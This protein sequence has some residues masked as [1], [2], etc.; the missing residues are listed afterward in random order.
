MPLALLQDLLMQKWDERID[1]ILC[2]HSLGAAIAQY[3]VL[4]LTRC[5]VG[6]RGGVLLEDRTI[7][8]FTLNV[9]QVPACLRQSHSGLHFR[10]EASSL[11]FC[12]PLEPCVSLFGRISASSF[13]PT[14]TIAAEQAKFFDHCTS[15]H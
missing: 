1:H 9:E 14:A 4:L 3:L 8:R 15:F 12:T 13:L 10:L 11:S 6:V 7:P 2:G 5:G